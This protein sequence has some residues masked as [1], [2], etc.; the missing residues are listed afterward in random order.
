M[1]RVIPL[2]SL[3]L[4]AMCANADTNQITQEKKVKAC[5]LYGT[6]KNSGYPIPKQKCVETRL[7]I[8][9]NE[10][11]VN[12]DNNSKIWRSYPMSDCSAP[13]IKAGLSERYLLEGV[14]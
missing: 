1:K 14:D 3:L 7:D 8:S 2:F 10:K 12:S 4:F 13:N 9:C 11:I 6:N 5:V